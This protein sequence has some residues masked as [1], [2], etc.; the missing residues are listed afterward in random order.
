MKTKLIMICVVL[1]IV[2][3]C[4]ACGAKEMDEQMESDY[5]SEEQDTTEDETDEKEDNS[6]EED[7]YS[8]NVHLVGDDI[9]A[10]TYVLKCISE[11]GGA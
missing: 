4:S 11:D 2:I 9:S 7:I 10:D 6:E 1:G 8:D 5:I 3:S